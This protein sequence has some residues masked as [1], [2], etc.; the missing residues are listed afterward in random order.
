MREQGVVSVNYRHGLR[1]GNKMTSKFFATG[2]TSDSDSD[3]GSSSSSSEE[4]KVVVKKQV[5]IK[6]ASNA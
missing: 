1:E 2:D 4:E 5:S 6:F 3:S